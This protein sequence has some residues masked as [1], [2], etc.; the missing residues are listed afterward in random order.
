MEKIVREVEA[1]LPE[2]TQNGQKMS[3]IIVLGLYHLWIK[4]SV[5]ISSL[6]LLTLVSVFC[7]RA[8]SLL[9]QQ[10]TRDSLTFIT[11]FSTLNIHNKSYKAVSE[12]MYV[13]K[14]YNISCN[15]NETIYNDVPFNINISMMKRKTKFLHKVC[16][17][18]KNNVSLDI[19]LLQN[20]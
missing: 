14:C 2:P 10:T 9:E 6:F 1:L 11:Q 18:W 12:K 4:K 5:I 7:K 17:S 20:R 3:C 15:Q 13:H 8:Q 19:N 16:A